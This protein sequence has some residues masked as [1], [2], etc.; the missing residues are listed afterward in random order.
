MSKDKQDLFVEP[1]K[2]VSSVDWLHIELQ[3]RFPKE[4][5]E[6][7]NNNQLSYEEMIQQAKAMHKEEVIKFAEDWEKSSLDCKED[8]YKETFGGNK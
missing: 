7:Y 3:K 2:K 6:M 5:Y 1:N 8:L 4:T